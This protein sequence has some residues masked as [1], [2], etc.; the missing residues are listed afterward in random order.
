MLRIA[1]LFE[2]SIGICRDSDEPVLAIFHD[3]TDKALRF[4]LL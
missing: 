1:D 4:H 2:K 3:L